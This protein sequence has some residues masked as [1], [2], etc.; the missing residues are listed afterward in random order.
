MIKAVSFDFDGTLVDSN[1]IKRQAYYRVTAHLAEVSPM[2]DDLFAGGFKGDRHAVFAELGKRLNLATEGLAE[3]YE[4]DCQAAISPLLERPGV[5]K[6][7]A[8]LKDRG[9]GLFVT[10][11]TPHDA[12]ARL[13]G[14]SPIAGLLDEVRGGPAGKLDI[15]SSILERHGLSAAQIA[16]VGDGADDRDAAGRLGCPFFAVEEGRPLEGSADMRRMLKAL[17]GEREPHV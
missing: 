14:G 5:G 17:E 3:R 15:L 11:A 9:L 1:R 7:L 2:L 12:L 4:D 8:Y 16:V 6:G 10:S 13:I